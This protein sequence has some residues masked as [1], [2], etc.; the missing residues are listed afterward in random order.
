MSINGE[1]LYITQSFTNIRYGIGADA[2]R[3]FFVRL[4]GTEVELV[5]PT[6]NNINQAAPS[7]TLAVSEQ[8]VVN[9][10]TTQLGAFAGG[11]IYKGPLPASIAAAAE[12]P[13]TGH[14]FKV[15]SAFT[16]QGTPVHLGDWVI[17]RS[18]TEFNVFK[19]IELLAVNNLTST[20][21]LAPLAANQGRVLNERINT[22][23][24]KK[25]DLIAGS[26]AV[27]AGSIV[28]STADGG[29]QRGFTVPAGET[30]NTN[31]QTASM[32][33]IPHERAIAQAL[34]ATA[35]SVVLRW[36]VD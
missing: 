4:D 28:T 31:V 17:F 15:A 24:A 32:T 34:A 35:Q 6:T 12:P 29:L 5:L 30:M 27:N 8:A 16:F 36:I 19:S 20:D 3:I 25:I 23:L 33:V 7:P 2:N 11:V 10:I 18:A 22:E 14:L 13:K 9:Y 1:W 26:N 21:Q